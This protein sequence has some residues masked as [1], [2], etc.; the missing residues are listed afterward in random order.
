M[1]NSDNLVITVIVFLL[2]QRV[3]HAVKGVCFDNSKEKTN[4][5][6]I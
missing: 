5:T 4:L 1:L 3:Y 6:G 2:N